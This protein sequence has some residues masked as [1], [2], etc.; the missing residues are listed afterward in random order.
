M[1]VFK[2]IKDMSLGMSVPKAKD[3]HGVKVTKATTRRYMQVMSDME[4]L[5]QKI[6]EAVFPGQSFEEVIKAARTADKA[7]LTAIVSTALSNMPT[8]LIEVLAGL[9]DVKQDQ[10]LDLTP[11]ELMD[12][13]QAWWALNDLSD[14]LK[15]VW[16]MIKKGTQTQQTPTGSKVG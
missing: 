6:M 10:L 15:G 5:P 1:R 16:G 2:K 3:I 4:D 11:K 14:F 7:Y 8:V 9:M 13:C 12:V